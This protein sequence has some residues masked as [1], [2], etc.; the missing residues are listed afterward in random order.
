MQRHSGAIL[1][2]V[3]LDHRMVKK[4]TQAGTNHFER[5]NEFEF[6]DKSVLAS[7]NNRSLGL[8]NHHDSS[9]C[10]FISIRL[11]HRMHNAFKL[12]SA[13]SH[14]QVAQKPY[15]NTVPHLRTGQW[16][17]DAQ[18][19]KPWCGDVV[20]A[21]SKIS[22]A[23]VSLPN[24]RNHRASRAFFHAPQPIEAVCM[25][26]DDLPCILEYA[27][28]RLH[29]MVRLCMYTRDSGEV[30][31]D[32]WETRPKRGCEEIDSLDYWWGR[33][34]FA[35]PEYHSAPTLEPNQPSD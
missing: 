13:R 3:L 31:T 21:A 5:D 20:P 25:K 17:C 22:G 1:T 35:L 18:L 7:S 12:G 30:N 11:S 4:G 33:R 26:I 16:C 34:I 15:H 8:D 10:P 6:F 23:C 24:P 28:S 19:N 27:S 32:Y 2:E 14:A 29:N 9:L